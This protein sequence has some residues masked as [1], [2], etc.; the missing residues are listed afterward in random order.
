MTKISGQGPSP[1]QTRGVGMLA[2]LVL[3]LSRL[4]AKRVLSATEVQRLASAAWD[5][6]CWSQG[7]TIG[8]KLVR[9]GNRGKHIGNV[10]RDVLRAAKKAGLLSDARPYRFM[11]PG[12]GQALTKASMLLPHEVMHE[13]LIR[14][15]S[16]ASLCLSPEQLASDTGLGPL[17]RQWAQ[18]P[19]V[20]SFTPSVSEVLILGLHADGVQY[21]CSVRAGGARSIFVGSVNIISG[22]TLASRGKRHFLFALSKRR[23]C[24]CGCQGFHTLQEVFYV[25]AW[26][27]RCLLQGVAPAVRHDG[28]PWSEE[29]AN[30]R[31]PAGS[32]LPRAALLQVRGDW[33]WL[34]QAFRFRSV[35]SESFCWMCE[36]TKSG[37]LTYRSFGVDAAHRATLI[38]H[39]AYILGC[40][41]AQQQ[42]SNIFRSPGMRLEH[43][44]VDAMHAGDLGVFQDIVGSVF[45]LEI[46]NKSWHRNAA[47]GLKV[48]NEELKNFYG[49]NPFLSELTLVMSQIRSS[50][51]GYPTLKAKAAQTRH[52][53]EFVM[54]LALRHV[55]GD[56]T[57]APYTFRRNSRLSLCSAEHRTLLVSVCTGMVRYHR[58]VA[59]E[60]FDR[61]RARPPCT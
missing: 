51:P 31:L 52:V 8:E 30:S 53:A 57:R 22:Q 54:M 33:E 40:M 5:D 35:N 17:L 2:K 43:V 10:H 39:E 6:G 44:G 23:L 41:Q 19:S 12:P 58:A 13:A 14:E 45:W 7:N 32:S 26:S 16:L 49:V 47:A 34:T 61:E 48:L 1:G 36:A 15:G 29:E 42:P 56:A 27:M 24:D 60:P 38:S 46:T 3:H 18:D 28:S 4:F 21:T 37:P 59:G 9:A 55:H 11:V 25:F 50:E 20:A